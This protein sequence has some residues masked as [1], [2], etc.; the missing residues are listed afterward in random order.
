H[1]LIGV[2]LLQTL[3]GDVLVLPGHHDDLAAETR[4]GEHVYC[5]FLG[6]LVLKFFLVPRERVL[7][8]GGKKGL[9]A[10]ALRRGPNRF[11]CVTCDRIKSRRLIRPEK[12]FLRALAEI[13]FRQR[14]CPI[15]ARGKARTRPSSRR[16]AE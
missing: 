16:A 8:G 5:G 14:L 15:L 10:P 3:V 2:L 4:V 9:E 11:F 13:S 7:V 12:G 6:L 1:Q